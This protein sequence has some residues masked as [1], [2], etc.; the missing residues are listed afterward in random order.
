MVRDREAQEK[1]R[2]FM[3]QMTPWKEPRLHDESRND[4]DWTEARACVT[5]IVGVHPALSF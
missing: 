5:A 2:P 1:K 4:K 3:I